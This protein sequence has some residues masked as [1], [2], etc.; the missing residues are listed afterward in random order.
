M[1]FRYGVVSSHPNFIPCLGSLVRVV[2]GIGEGSPAQV[3]EL[4]RLGLALTVI[5]DPDPVPATEPEPA[6]SP[7][8]PE[9]PAPSTPASKRA[10]KARP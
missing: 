2:D 10:R 5:P 6:A 3:E 4:A 1:R 8:E 9:P 7:A